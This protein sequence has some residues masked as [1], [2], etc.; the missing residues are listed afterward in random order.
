MKKIIDVE[1]TDS[2][3]IFKI[4]DKFLF[5]KKEYEESIDID[6]IG[7]IEKNFEGKISDRDF[8]NIVFYKRIED[9]EGINFGAITEEM[10][11][12]EILQEIIHDEMLLYQIPAYKY[13]GKIP[14]LFDEIMKHIDTSKVEI[15]EIIL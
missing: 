13:V 8:T 11:N 9:L 7:K 12:N 14:E 1:V 6:K 3:I 2:K 10:A 4:R 5:Y 15:V